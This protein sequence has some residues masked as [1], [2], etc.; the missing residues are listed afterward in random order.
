MA[1]GIAK[2]QIDEVIGQ[3]VEREPDLRVSPRNMRDLNAIEAE[4]TRLQRQDLL[5]RSDLLHFG[6]QTIQLAAAEPIPPREWTHTHT[7]VAD[8]QPP[9]P[10]PGVIFD[11][12]QRSSFDRPVTPEYHDDKDILVVR[13]MERRGP[14]SESEKETEFLKPRIST[15]RGKRMD[16]SELFK[17]LRSAD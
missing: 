4:I 10:N 17:Q 1:S 6:G 2:E 7:I 8:Q 5:T 13:P 14:T 3:I 11:D 15:G 16:Y 9:T 12:D